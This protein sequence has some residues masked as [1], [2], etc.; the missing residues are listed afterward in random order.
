[1]EEE[2]SLGKYQPNAAKTELINGRTQK[3]QRS[4]DTI[5]YKDHDCLSK[6]NRNTAL[7]EVYGCAV[8]WALTMK[9]VLMYLGS[10]SRAI[11]IVF[12]CI[13]IQL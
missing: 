3:S 13:S 4:L 10:W 8:D 12:C 5:C 6:D 1:M 9:D 11:G 7:T 2:V